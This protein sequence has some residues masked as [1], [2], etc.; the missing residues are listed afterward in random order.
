[1]K[2]EKW[3]FFMVSKNLD[4]LSHTFINQLKTVLE[5]SL[6]KA[7]NLLAHNR[8]TYAKYNIA[9]STLQ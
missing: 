8:S 2:R 7:L 6:T 5:I 3:L 1:M 4:E 9:H